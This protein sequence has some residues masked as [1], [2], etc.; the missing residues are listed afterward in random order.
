MLRWRLLLGTVIIAALVGLCWADHVVPIPGA[1]LLPLALLVTVLAGGEVL[2]VAAAGGIHPSGWVVHCGNLLIVVAGWVP[3]VVWKLTAG[4]PSGGSIVGDGGLAAAR[5]G[6]LLALAAGLILAVLSEMLRYQ[7]PGSVTVNLAGAVLAIVYVGLLLSF[8]VQLRLAFGIA[9]L[10]S[11]VI[12]VKT[13]DTGAYAVGR[14]AGRHKMAPVLSPGKTVEGAVGGL[15]FACLGSWATFA[16]LVPVLV[17]DRLEPGTWWGWILFGLLVGAAGM[18]G[19]LA[20]SLIKR[21]A[22]RKDSGPWMPGFGGVLDILD[23]I[24]LAAPVA[25]VCWGLGLVGT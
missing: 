19:D 21:D 3:A 20:E 9:A 6:I 8:M 2:A 16:W 14:L 12:V 24:L 25:Y 22:G 15:V 18:I 11:L 13:G 17:P 1:V 4:L 7:R 23:S 10:A 5:E